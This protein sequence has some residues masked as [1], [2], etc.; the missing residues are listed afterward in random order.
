M[1]VENMTDQTNEVIANMIPIEIDGADGFRKVKETLTR[2]G[3]PSRSDNK[4]FQSVHILHKRGQYYL[5]H[6]KQMFSLDGRDATLTE[7]DIAR[8]N[9]IAVMLEDWG[10][11]NVDESF[12]LTPMGKPSMVKVIKHSEA[13]D[14]ELCQ[15]YNI[16]NRR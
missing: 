8:R 13:G 2:M 3:V 12:D 14:W 7:G 5:C 16:G 11:V 15:K 6:F 4:L 10:L 9:R 1:T